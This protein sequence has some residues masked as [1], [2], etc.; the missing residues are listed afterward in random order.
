MIKFEDGWFF[1]ICI[2]VQVRVHMS[3]CVRIDVKKFDEEFS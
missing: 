1:Y 3:A 2:H